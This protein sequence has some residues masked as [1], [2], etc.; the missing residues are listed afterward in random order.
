[1]FGID[2]IRK[3]ATHSIDSREQEVASPAAP[4]M[5]TIITST[6]RLIGILYYDISRMVFEIRE[7][8]DY[9]KGRINLRPDLSWH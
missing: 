4:G 5:S 6:L 7:S 3:A 9:F 8:C 2:F 1:M